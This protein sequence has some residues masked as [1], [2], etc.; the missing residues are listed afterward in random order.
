MINSLWI[1]K[2]GMSA[3]QTQLDVISHNLANVST[4]GF[5]RNS[6]VFEDLIYQNLRQ[7]G[8]QT[9]EENQLPTGLHLG[10]GVRTV[11]T[12]RHFT[13][14]SLQ[15]SSNSLDVAINGNGFFEV[16]LP[17][18]TIGYTRDGSF[19]LDAQG[20]MVTSGGLPVAN[21]ITVPQGATSISIS[22]TGVVSA[23]IAGN[24]QPQQ[25]GQLAMSSF[26][27]AAGLQPVGQN[28]YKESA[29]SGPPQQGQPGTNGLGV[30]KQGFLE[31]SN[32]NVV[33]ELVTMIQTQRAYEM[34]S[35]AIQTSDQMLAKLSQL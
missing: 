14:G 7:V 20:R 22:E 34:N 13:Q 3:Q 2:T 12:S 6:A 17:D 24:A 9:T 32:V 29:A 25:L 10:L 11:A 31:T 28:M 18:G 8:A 30:I 26:I 1:A 15:Q 4:T 35:K 5:K 21:G 16:Q 33:E 27:N 19:Q 23:T